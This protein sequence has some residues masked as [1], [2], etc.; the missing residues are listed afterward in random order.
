MLSYKALAVS[1]AGLTAIL[2]GSAGRSLK[3]PKININTIGKRKLKNNEDGWLKMALKLAFVT[4][5]KA[6]D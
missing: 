6:L 5:H 3:A 1:L 4:A 2:K